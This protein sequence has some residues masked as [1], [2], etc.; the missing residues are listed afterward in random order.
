MADSMMLPVHNSDAGVS[1]DQ[2]A[3]EV[4]DAQKDLELEKQKKRTNIVTV[5]VFGAILVSY[6]FQGW[7]FGWNFGNVLIAISAVSGA[8]VATTTAVKQIIM[9]RMDTL[10]VVHNKIRQEVNRFMEENNNLTRNVDGLED[11]TIE[12]QEVTQQLDRIAEK[13]GASAQELVTLVKENAETIKEQK[14][15]L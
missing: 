4:N 5:I 2:Q 1:L 7:V 15:S 6:G 10:R 12:L 11:K 3:V 14:V 9:Q 8:V 13:Q